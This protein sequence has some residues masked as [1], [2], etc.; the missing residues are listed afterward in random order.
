MHLTLTYDSQ[1]LCLYLGLEFSVGPRP[2][3][4]SYMLLQNLEGVLK[5]RQVSLC[6]HYTIHVIGPVLM[7]WGR[8]REVGP[9]CHYDTWWGW[10][11]I[12]GETLGRSTV[13]PPPEGKLIL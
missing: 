13:V 9:G 8:R 11:D 5:Q 7:M 3:L 10:T 4:S 2:I 6:E 12:L 1:T